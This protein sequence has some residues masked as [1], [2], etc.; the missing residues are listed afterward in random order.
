MWRGGKSQQLHSEA[1]ERDLGLSELVLQPRGLA[2]GSRVWTGQVGAWEQGWPQPQA[3]HPPVRPGFLE[4]LPPPPPPAPRP[5]LSGQNSEAPASARNRAE[6]EDGILH[7]PGPRT[8]VT[9]PSENL[10]G[11]SSLFPHLVVNGFRT[12]SP[13]PIQ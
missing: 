7:S 4:P 13:R 11:L 2:R 6:W 12:P 1:E 5:W 10:D 8:D 3:T 9:P